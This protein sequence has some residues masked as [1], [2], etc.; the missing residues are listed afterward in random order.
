MGKRLLSKVAGES[1][2]KRILQSGNQPSFAQDVNYER[3]NYM[4]L[5]NNFVSYKKQF[6]LLMEWKI[7]LSLKKQYVEDSLV[8]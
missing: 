5:F 6:F 7:Y 8:L 1:I 2:I 4:L 3:I